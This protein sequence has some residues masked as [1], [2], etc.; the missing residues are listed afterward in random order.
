MCFKTC[1]SLFPLRKSHNHRLAWE[2]GLSPCETVVVVILLPCGDLKNVVPHQII[3]NNKK[4]T[5]FNLLRILGGKYSLNL[6]LP[7]RQ[8][9]HRADTDERDF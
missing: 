1:L 2:N 6:F 4:G 7:E 8:S 3:N 5:F 9:L